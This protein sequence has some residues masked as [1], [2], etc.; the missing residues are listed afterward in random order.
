MIP[1][2][3]KSRII[4]GLLCLIRHNLYKMLT[5]ASHNLK[6][7]GVSCQYMKMIFEPNT[8]FLWIT[9]VGMLIV[10]AVDTVQKRHSYLGQGGSE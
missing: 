7:R 10:C 6:S 5:Y 2:T 3:Q 9:S 4:P 8:L 1:R